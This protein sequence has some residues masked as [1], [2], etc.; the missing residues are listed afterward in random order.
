MDS[1]KEKLFEYSYPS[2]VVESVIKY[3][4]KKP[5]V[6]ELP[7]KDSVGKILAQDL[8]ALKDKPEH[9]LSHVD[10]F[11]VKAKGTIRATKE[12]PVKL[13]IVREIDPRNAGK[14][15][16]KEGET[17]YVDTGF[18][19]PLNSDA[20]IPIENVKIIGGKE[21]LVFTP[22]KKGE[23]VIPRGIDFRKGDILV[24]KQTLLTGIHLRILFDAGYSKIKVFNPPRVSIFP[25]GDE[26][27]SMNDYQNQP[28]KIP[29]TSTYMVKYLLE[30]MP[31]EV[32]LHEILPD[33]P[34]IIV[35]RIKKELEKPDVDI[36]ITISGVSLGRK[37][38]SW[39]SLKK[40]LNPK[41]V[42]RGVKMVQGR[43]NSGMVVKDKIIFN[44]P[45]FIQAT[46]AGTVILVLPVISYLNG[47]GKKIKLPCTE[48]RLSETTDF[49]EKR[50]DFYRIRFVKKDGNKIKI[51]TKMESS[52]ASL[53]T[54]TEG[55]VIIP[56]G[57]R[58]L[59]RN[60]TIKVFI[61]DYKNADHGKCVLDI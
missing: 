5:T 4:G 55:F 20:S 30:I 42:F 48:Y 59:E 50:L 58:K 35:S 2:D 10:G 18:P 34:E 37:D 31:V 52:M 9:D 40:E 43:A 54:K 3:S 49:G 60:T 39:I 41:Y 8:I 44:L 1:M 19:M 28:G 38:H 29:E 61:P 12:K 33:K 13:K 46:F 15:E 6:V 14:Y 22:V 45:G 21:I 56:P 27:V 26:L 7:V 23:N 16:L 57:I 51:I 24:K 36:I 53:F 47:L 11:A 32:K 25:I 17:V